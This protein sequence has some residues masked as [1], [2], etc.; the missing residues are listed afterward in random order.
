MGHSRASSPQAWGTHAPPGP[1]RCSRLFFLGP[2]F[3]TVAA[4]TYSAVL[5]SDGAKLLMAPRFGLGPSK[6]GPLITRS[7]RLPLS[8]A[9]TGAH[10]VLVFRPRTL[11][12]SAWRVSQGQCRP[13]LAGQRVLH[14]ACWTLCHLPPLP[15]PGS[16]E[17]KRASL[18]IVLSSSKQRGVLVQLATCGSTLDLHVSC[19][20]VGGNGSGV[21]GVLP[22]KWGLQ[23][24]TERSTQM[25][26]VNWPRGRGSVLIFPIV[27]PET[28]LHTLGQLR[29]ISFSSK[30]LI[31]NRMLATNSH[32]IIEDKL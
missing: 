11:S 25:P 10:D 30:T 27:I 20:R 9:A 31:L 13:A 12:G 19:W 29:L 22:T 21:C 15:G 24:G 23:K 2:G 16:L 32:L 18:G 6:P 5:A 26:S 7:V 14:G 4:A 3:Q 28:R 17:L 8:F 1:S